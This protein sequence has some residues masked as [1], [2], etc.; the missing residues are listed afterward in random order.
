MGHEGERADSYRF[1]RF[2]GV[3]LAALNQALIML[4]V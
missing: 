4:V 1:F 2:A 3:G